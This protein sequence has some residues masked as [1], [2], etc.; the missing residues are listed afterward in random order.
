MLDMKL[1]NR[2]VLGYS[3]RYT[4]LPLLPTLCMYISIEYLKN[5]DKNLPF[6]LLCPENE[7][8]DTI[9]WRET[10]RQIQTLQQ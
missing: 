2:H 4:F 6:K 8:Q 5:S 1:C 7:S 3:K 10:M 9:I